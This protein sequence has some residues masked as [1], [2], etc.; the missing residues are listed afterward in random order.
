MN[1]FLY[2]WRN[3]Y[4]EFVKIMNINWNVI[5]IYKLELELPV[6]FTQSII[7]LYET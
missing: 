4:R 3:I 5:K 1:T 7:S 2:T 6:Q